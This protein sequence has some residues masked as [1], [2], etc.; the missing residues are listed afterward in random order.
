MV[1]RIK[2][3]NT[4]IWFAIKD[5]SLKSQYTMI[6]LEADAV[7]FCPLFSNRV[8]FIT[9][10]RWM[11]MSGFTKLINIGKSRRSS[12]VNRFDKCDFE[13]CLKHSKNNLSQEN[14]TFGKKQKKDRNIFEFY[15]GF[16]MSSMQRFQR[17]KYLKTFNVLRSIC[18]AIYILLLGYLYKLE[19]SSQCVSKGNTTISSDCQILYPIG[20]FSGI[21]V[22][23]TNA[24]N[25]DIRNDQGQEYEPQ[26][27]LKIKS[28]TFDSYSSSYGFSN[29]GT[30]LGSQTDAPNRLYK[31]SAINID[32]QSISKNN[33]HLSSFSSSSYD[34]NRAP[35]ILRRTFSDIQLQQL[36]RSAGCVNHEIK[37]VS[38]T[39][40]II[41]IRN[42][43]IIYLK[44][45]F[46]HIMC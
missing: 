33:H 42:I 14:E 3:F 20:I 29:T 37:L 15:V 38:C 30:K 6:A 41:I 4:T 39:Y 8:V 21:F 17:T 26:S 5:S 7:D 43:I 28:H 24:F 25:G 1:Y 32:S 10:S 11:W 34:P 13:G 22:S 44:E 27:N 2:E 36:L 12:H 19:N 31:S 18:F 46:I 45:I 40:K 23:A 9:H 16:L 35:N